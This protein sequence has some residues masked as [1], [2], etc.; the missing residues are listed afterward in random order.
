MLKYLLIGGLLMVCGCASVKYTNTAGE[1]F[2]YFRFGWMEIQGF[3]ADIAKEKK[4]I[5][6]ESSKG[7]G[8]EMEK[9]FLNLTEVIKT[10][11]VP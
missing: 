6:L 11:P 2:E 9:A 5:S 7:T 8:G 1:T 10:V 4:V 3:S